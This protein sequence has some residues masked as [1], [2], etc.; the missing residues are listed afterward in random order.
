M[1]QCSWLCKLSHIAWGVR[2]MEM[3]SPADAARSR[4]K[5]K[6]RPK[7]D[8]LNPVSLPGQAKLGQADRRTR[9]LRGINI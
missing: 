4:N 9:Y 1:A 2:D 3:I 5:I 7:C 6:A 8:R